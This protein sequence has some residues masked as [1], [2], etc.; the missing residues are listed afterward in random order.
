MQKSSSRCFSVS[1]NTLYL[2]PTHTMLVFPLQCM[3]LFATLRKH[4]SEARAYDKVLLPGKRE[5]MAAHLQTLLVKCRFV[6]RKRCNIST[7]QITH[8]CGELVRELKR[9]SSKLQKVS[10]SSAQADISGGVRH[11]CMQDTCHKR[12]VATVRSNNLHVPK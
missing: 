5:E 9:G 3:H 8:K 10:G 2:I 1:S 6:S 11:V 12:G 7:H 4:D